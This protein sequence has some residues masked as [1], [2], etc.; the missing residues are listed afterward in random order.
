MKVKVRVQLNN[1]ESRYLTVE[2]EDERDCLR[3][4]YIRAYGNEEGEADNPQ[5]IDEYCEVAE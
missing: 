3:S 5:L 4:A 2:G 1:G